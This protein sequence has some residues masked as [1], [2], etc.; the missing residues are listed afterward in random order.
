M[1]AIIQVNNL[2][3][4]FENENGEVNNVLENVNFEI[5]ENEFV[6]VFGPGQCGKTTL[7][8]IIAGLENATTGEVLKKGV[9]VEKPGPDRAMVFQNILLFQIILFAS[10]NY[11]YKFSIFTLDIPIVICYSKLIKQKGLRK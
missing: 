6:V 11:F 4:S 5:N 10:F 2:N 1:D 9:R 8:N 7:L 3:K